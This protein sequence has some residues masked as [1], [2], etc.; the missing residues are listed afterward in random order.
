MMY[1]NSKQSVIRSL[2]ENLHPSIQNK[3]KLIHYQIHSGFTE[4]EIILI[5][6][7]LQII[8]QRLFKPEIL[9]NM[10]RVCG[11]SGVSLA[12][13]VW[14]RSQLEKHPEYHQRHDLLRFQLMCLE[15]VKFPTIHLYP[16]YEKSDTQARGNLGCVSCIAHRSTFSI[17]GNFQMKLN[18][19]NLDV[20]NERFQANSI[21]WAGTI[22]H[23]ML[24]NLGH[25]HVDDDYSDRW[26]INVL[27]NSFIYDGNYSGL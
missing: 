7:A 21:Y 4:N 26:Q 13:Q 18:R 24:H 5:E 23:E 20:D 12:K 19:Y 22:V 1:Y 6:N 17:Q 27:E 10:Y 2:I 11:T 16:I 25:Q 8:D 14:S 9:Q 15:K 3:N